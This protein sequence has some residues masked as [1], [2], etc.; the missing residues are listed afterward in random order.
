M[1]NN[2]PTNNPL[3]EKL[4]LNIKKILDTLESL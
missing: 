4:K 1:Q 3:K 2:K